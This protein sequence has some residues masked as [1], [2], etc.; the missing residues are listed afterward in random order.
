MRRQ[1][2][3]WRAL[4]GGVPGLLGAFLCAAVTA[5]F[6]QVAPGAP[7]GAFGAPQ[8]PPGAWQ[9]SHGGAPAV[10]DASVASPD[11]EDIRD[12]RGPKAVAPAW[13]LPAVAAAA[14]L[15]AVGA[16]VYWR[17]RRRRPRPL[18]PFEIALQRLE[19]IRP[20][21]VPPRAAEFS[22]AV[23]DIVRG[24]IEQRFEVT[25][26]RQ[27]T[28]E[29]LRDIVDSADTPLARH[30]AVLGRFLQQCDFVKFGGASLSVPSMESL[31][32]SARTFVRET[33][34]ADAA[35]DAKGAHDSLPAT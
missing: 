25:A 27:T 28:E 19:D 15:L 22:V 11:S 30:R 13:Q 21:M 2:F 33:A 4:R 34:Q 7:P 20:L 12:I 9:P 8:A 6:A 26:T 29:F 5:S 3:L 14:L 10:P 16:Y 23:S 35:V 18:L 1:V 32:Q 31:R 17:I 24:Y